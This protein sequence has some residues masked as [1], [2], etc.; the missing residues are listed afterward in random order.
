[1]VRSRDA[2]ELWGKLESFIADSGVPD[3]SGSVHFLGAGKRLEVFMPFQ[4]VP[5]NE[6][7]LVGLAMSPLCPEVLCGTS[8]EQAAVANGDKMVFR[9]EEEAEKTSRD[10]GTWEADAYQA[11]VENLGVCPLADLWGEVQHRDGQKIL[12]VPGLYQDFISL[13]FPSIQIQT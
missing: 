2:A 4:K 7:V 3:Y 13:P 8:L 10:L 1:M 12:A 5:W 9:L 6:V 11:S